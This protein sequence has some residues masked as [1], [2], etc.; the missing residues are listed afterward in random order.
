M[1]IITEINEIQISDLL[2]LEL[3]I[4][5]CKRIV[6]SK[7]EMWRHISQLTLVLNNCK[8]QSRICFVL[9]P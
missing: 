3:Y 1:E 9:T 8:T 7:E 4:K 2:T 5:N 6:T